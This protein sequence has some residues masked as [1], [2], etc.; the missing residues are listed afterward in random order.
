MNRILVAAALLA[1][2][3]APAGAV[4]I[5]HFNAAITASRTRSISPR[6]RIHAGRSSCCRTFMSS[7]GASPPTIS[8]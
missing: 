4:E 1:A 2:F 5:P 6:P 8:R 7:C 3:S